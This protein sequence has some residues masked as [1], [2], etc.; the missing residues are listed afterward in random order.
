MKALA[1]QFLLVMSV[2]QPFIAY[3]N[4]CYFTLRSGGKT[5]I[6]FVFDSGALWL[7]SVPAAFVIA[8]FTALP[9]VPF[10]TVIEALN[11]IKCLIG[12]VMVKQKRWVVNLV[13]ERRA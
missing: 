2:M 13:G 12:Y 5:V 10:F 1:V 3:T 6:T 11:L 7:I 8:H 4:A 9:I